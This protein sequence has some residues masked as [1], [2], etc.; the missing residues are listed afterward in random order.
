[1]QEV[2]ARQQAVSVCACTLAWRSPIEKADKTQ[3]SADATLSPNLDHLHSSPSRPLLL[4]YQMGLPA[5][6]P[7]RV[8]VSVDW[9]GHT[10]IQVYVGGEN[11]A[12]PVWLF[13]T[14]TLSTHLPRTIC[15]VLDSIMDCPLDCSLQSYS[16]KSC[17]YQPLVQIAEIHI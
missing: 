15:V 1:M 3:F 7:M 8:V 5:K 6:F 4:P 13:S 12:V 9:S 14:V 10:H 16:F 11:G 2:T 17:S